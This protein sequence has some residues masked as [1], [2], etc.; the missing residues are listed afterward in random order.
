MALGVTIAGCCSADAQP[1]RGDFGAKSEATI[2]IS[3]SV[4]PR[5]LSSRPAST[6]DNDSSANA[7][8]SF[9]ANA[10][11]LRYSVRAMPAFPAEGSLAESDPSARQSDAN[12]GNANSAD[13]PAQ[14]TERAGVLYLIVPD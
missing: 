3:V 4:V 5:F 11:T 2:R 14:Q 7:L 12:G 10:P 6:G 1:A 13:S 9:A 8:T